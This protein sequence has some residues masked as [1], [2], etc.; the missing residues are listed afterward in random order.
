MRL[1]ATVMSR[2]DSIPNDIDAF[3]GI[4]GPHDP[5]CVVLVASVAQGTLPVVFTPLS[6]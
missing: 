3:T 4:C 5:T 6:C 2:K 1:Q